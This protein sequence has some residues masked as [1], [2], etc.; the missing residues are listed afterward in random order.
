MHALDPCFLI[1]KNQSKRVN[2][3]VPRQWVCLRSVSRKIVL[4][5]VVPDMLQVSLRA[6]LVGILM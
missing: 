5:F 3:K 4:L 1:L 6:F 2:L